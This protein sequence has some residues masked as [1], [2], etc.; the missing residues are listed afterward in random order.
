MYPLGV[1]AKVCFCGEAIWAGRRRI[2]INRVKRENHFDLITLVQQDIIPSVQL[3]LN[4]INTIKKIKIHSRL[5]H[6]DVLF[7]P[8]A[9]A[10]GMESC[11]SGHSQYWMGEVQS[12]L[13]ALNIGHPEVRCKQI[14]EW[15]NYSWA[16]ARRV[17]WVSRKYSEAKL[18]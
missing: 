17:H 5:V 18:H 13:I 14:L 3:Y 1:Q 16:F 10:G 4:K 2:H 15:K 7:F 9:V 11:E 12:V 6:I 8:H